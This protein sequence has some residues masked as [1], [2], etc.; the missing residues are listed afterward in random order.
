MTNS[1]EEKFVVFAVEAML[2]D[3]EKVKEIDRLNFH[4]Q[5]AGIVGQT[6][7]KHFQGITFQKEPGLTSFLMPSVSSRAVDVKK[8]GNPK[9][10]NDGNPKLID[11]FE[12]LASEVGVPSIAKENG[13]SVRKLMLWATLGSKVNSD[14]YMNM[15]D[16]NP[17]EQLFSINYRND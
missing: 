4:H 15:A 12:M 1:K 2:H 6:F 3:H 7:A 9:E 16:S 10:V 8:I 5:L 11:I 17:S 14:G 13:I